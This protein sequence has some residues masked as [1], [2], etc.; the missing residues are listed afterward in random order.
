L[1]SGERLRAHRDL[2]PRALEEALRSYAPVKLM[3]RW[4]VTETTI[5]D[6]RR[7]AG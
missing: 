5:G 1:E 7:E 2:V 3:V 6:Q 4:V